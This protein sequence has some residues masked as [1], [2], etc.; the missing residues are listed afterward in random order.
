[1]NTEEV[2][3]H[4]NAYTSI[5]KWGFILAVSYFAIVLIQTG[6]IL[7][8]ERDFELIDLLFQFADEDEGRVRMYYMVYCLTTITDGKVNAFVDDFQSYTRCELDQGIESLNGQLVRDI[9]S[10][11]IPANTFSLILNPVTKHL[12]ELSSIKD[13]FACTASL[14]ILWHKRT[15]TGK[16]IKIS[17]LDIQFSLLE[18]TNVNGPVF[19]LLKFLGENKPRINDHSYY[20]HG[21]HLYVGHGAAS[22]YLADP[23]S[24]ISNKVDLSQRRTFDFDKNYSTYADLLDKAGYR[25]VDSVLNTTGENIILKL[26]YSATRPEIHEGNAYEDN[27]VFPSRW[28]W[29]VQKWGDRN[30][31]VFVNKFGDMYFLLRWPISDGKAVSPISF[32]ATPDIPF[33]DQARFQAD[34]SLIEAQLLSEHL[35]NFEWRQWQQ[36][37]DLSLPLIDFHKQL[38]QQLFKAK[39]EAQFKIA[40]IPIPLLPALLLLAFILAYTV[41]TQAYILRRLQYAGN[42]LIIQSVAT[43]LPYPELHVGKYAYAIR[44][45]KSFSPV[46]LAGLSAGIIIRHDLGDNLLLMIPACVILIATCF[47]I[48]FLNRHF[49]KMLLMR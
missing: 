15:S 45:T 42:I 19:E 8:I 2:T 20:K 26:R 39:A 47:G 44:L 40:E 30:Y 18:T 25:L 14:P 34:Y 43:G 27:L 12:K 4:F 36:G 49:K 1:M 31:D 33:S 46:V 11:T 23:S 21:K 9:Y 16:S 29:P 32:L 37:S 41:L 38:R 6:K 13:I 35:Q 10:S 22:V 5:R 17:L 48:Y 7:Q 24:R 3:R 28:R